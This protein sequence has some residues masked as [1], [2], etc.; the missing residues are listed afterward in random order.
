MPYN[1][2]H[3]A[4]ILYFHLS[5]LQQTT[6]MCLKATFLFLI[7]F[8]IPAVIFLCFKTLKAKQVNGPSAVQQLSAQE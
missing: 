3:W 6:E 7:F 8:K 1:Y 5:K 2:I 4:E